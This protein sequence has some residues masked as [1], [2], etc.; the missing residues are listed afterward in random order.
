MRFII[1]VYRSLSHS[2]NTLDVVVEERFGIPD[3][4]SLLYR[5]VFIY[6]CLDTE[7]ENTFRE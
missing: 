3:T 6:F 1:V 5:I 4:R 7:W 2:N